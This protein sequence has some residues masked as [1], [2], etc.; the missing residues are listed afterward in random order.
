MTRLITRFLLAAMSLISVAQDIPPQ[1]QSTPSCAIDENSIFR[2]ARICGKSHEGSL[3]KA[4][5]TVTGFTI[6]YSALEDVKRR[7]G[8]SYEFKLSKEMEASTGICLK[9]PKGD[10]VVFSSGDLAEP[11]ILS[12]IFLARAKILEQQGAKCLEV[13]KLAGNITIRSGIRLGMPKQNLLSQLR[14]TH[15]KGNAFNVDYATTPDRA[16]WVSTKFKLQDAKGWIAMSGA[17]GGF[18][19]GQLRWIVLYGSVSN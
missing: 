5:L 8:G 10:A 12:S 3:A 13:S 16:P 9:N 19:G 4:D 18:Q 11:R 15:S 14:L 6:G 1:T 7:F 17:Y 2:E